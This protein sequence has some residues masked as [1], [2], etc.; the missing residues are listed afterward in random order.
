MKGEM[1][2]GR[3][4]KRKKFNEGEGRYSSLLAPYGERKTI[5]H[6]G[7]KVV[8]NGMLF[9]FFKRDINMILNITFFFLFFFFFYFFIFLFFL[10]FFCINSNKNYFLTLSHPLDHNF[11]FNSKWAC[12]NSHIL[13]SKRPRLELSP[14]LPL[15]YFSH[16][17]GTIFSFDL[18]R[19]EAVHALSICFCF[20]LIE[21]FCF[22]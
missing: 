7:K 21:V 16:L 13:Y 9:F 6:K 4:V 10:F 18:I 14:L 5:L 12:K 17:F 11:S 8:K 3:D 1:E 19:I 2:K 15:P 22:C 20:F